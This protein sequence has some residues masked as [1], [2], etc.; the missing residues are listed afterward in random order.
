MALSLELIVIAH[1]PSSV[2]SVVSVVSGIGDCAHPVYACIA[3][4]V[5][6]VSAILN[7]GRDTIAFRTVPRVT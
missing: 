6:I 3:S 7:T 4:V 2:L 5:S 1:V